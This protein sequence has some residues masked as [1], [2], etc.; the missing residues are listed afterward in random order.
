[1]TARRQTRVAGNVRV[2]VLAFALA[3]GSASLAQEIPWPTPAV[4]ADA[5]LSSPG[6]VMAVNGMPLKVY[7]Y[8]TA[9]GSD[10]LSRT[11]RAGL[12]GEPVRREPTA[13]DPRLTLAGREDG[14]WIT[15]QIAPPQDGLTIATWSAMPRFIDGARRRMVMPPGFPADA[16][17]LEHVESYDD[18]KRSQMAIGRTQAPVDAAVTRFLERMK[19]LGYTKQP[20]PPRN[21]SGSSEYSAVFANGREEIVV[22]MQQ[23]P[24][25]TA[26]VFNRISALERLQ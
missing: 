17:L 13:V 22:S 21:W 20:F 6:E 3:V 9:A 26:V 11:F 16:Q 2:A 23:E 5:K 18:D 10:Q 19:E 7:R 4:P 1:M 8:V 15:L 12:D 14:F 25:G 24:Q